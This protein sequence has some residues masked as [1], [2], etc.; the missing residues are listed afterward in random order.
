MTNQVVV[1]IKVDFDKLS[2]LSLILLYLGDSA[3]LNSSV[4]SD[5]EFEE[6]GAFFTDSEGDASGTFINAAQMDLNLN[7]YV[8]VSDLKYG[9]EV[10]DDRDYYQF[11]DIASQVPVN[12]IEENVLNYPTNLSLFTFPRNDFSTFP[13]PKLRQS[14]LFDYY[15]VDAAS[16]LPALVLNIQ[17]GDYVGDFCAAPGGKSLLL[18]LTLREC[19]FFLNE[20]SMSRFKRLQNVFSSFIPR[21]SLANIEFSNCDANKLR[22]IDAFDKIL[23]DAPCTNDRHS[24]YV[25]DNNIFAPKRINERINMPAKQMDILL[26]ALNSVKPGGTVVYSTCSL[27]PIQNDGVVHMALQRIWQE[28]T[29][30]FSVVSLKEALRPLRGTFRFNHNFKYGTQV[31]PFLPSNFGPM[32]FC[33]LVR[34]D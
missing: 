7:D 24:L 31:L 29:R 14:N 26:S 15:L 21:S 25:N 23:V 28:S 2:S 1:Q 6:I 3:F 10:V 33:K 5:S 22:K 9:E 30:S 12:F 20:V 32:Y 16:A 19:R 8:P 13:S 4:T 27:S 34:T 18:F 11:Y 17:D